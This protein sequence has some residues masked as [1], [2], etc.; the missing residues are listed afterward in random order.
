MP[1]DSSGNYTLPAGNPV[2]TGTIIASDWANDTMP[3][4]AAA[5]TDSLSRSGDGGMQV[6]LKQIDGSAGA[7]SYS[8][9][10]SSLYGMYLDLANKFL[11]LCAGGVDSLK[12]KSTG[13]DVVGILNASGA[14]NI[15]GLLSALAGLAVTGNITVSGTVDGVDI[16]DLAS[17]ALVD[18]DIGVTV[19]GYDA[20]TVK[21][22]VA[23]TFV[24][25]VGCDV[26]AGGSAASFT[27]DFNLE[28]IKT[29][30]VTGA[31]TL[32]NPSNKKAGVYHLK[33][34]ID[35]T[36]N[37]TTTFDTDYNVVS[38]VWDSSANA[39]NIVTMVSDGTN[40]YCYIAQEV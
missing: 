38:G 34:T 12:V 4:V 6:A 3:D 14:T 22:D 20:D 30:T 5:L 24:A 25:G 37:Y 23:A 28:N 11:G 7:P 29:W 35:A 21:Q 17:N 2:I 13:V 9:T 33:A 16:A 1:R 10:N 36:G 32:N 19:Q 18:A 31:G 8:F 15:S 39:V 26:D 27:P 40:V